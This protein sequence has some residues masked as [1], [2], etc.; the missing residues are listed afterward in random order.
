MRKILNS[1]FEKEDLE[2][3]NSI[4][5]MMGLDAYRIAIYN[6]DRLYNELKDSKLLKANSNGYPLIT[7]DVM[8]LIN[9]KYSQVLNIAKK[10]LESAFQEGIDDASKKESNDEIS[11]FIDPVTGKKEKRLGKLA[12]H[13]PNAYIKQHPMIQKAVDKIKDSQTKWDIF[14]LGPKMVLKLFDGMETGS[15]ILERN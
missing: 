4:P 2:G 8:S 15:N 12:Y 6:D 5:Q 13:G 3:I 11:E 9:K 7:N 10:N 14:T 1:S